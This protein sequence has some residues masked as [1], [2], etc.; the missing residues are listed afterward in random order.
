MRTP[1]DARLVQQDVATALAEDLGAGDLTAALIAPGT[2]LNTKVISRENAVLAGRPWFDAT[3]EAL[4]GQVTV[5]WS[6]EDG[7]DLRAGQI[8]CELEGDAASLLSGERTALNFL[9][10]LSATATA[11]KAFVEKI[12]GTGARILD[13]R[14]TLPGLRRAQKYAVLCGGG[15][16][17]R[18]GLFD[19]ILIKENHISAAGGIQAAVSAAKQQSPDVMIEVEV[20]DLQELRE[21]LAAGATRALLDNFSLAQLHEAVAEGGN[22]ELEASGDIGLDTVRQVAETG[23]DFISVGAIT[24]HVRA[25]DFSMRFV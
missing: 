2:R 13:T 18:I 23:V 4:P 11:T 1:P 9:Q 22:I 15:C 8:V 6:L 3:F 24:K 19:A 21:A 17:H 14:K 12:E 20:E 25:I 10:T 5:N 16:N 7:E